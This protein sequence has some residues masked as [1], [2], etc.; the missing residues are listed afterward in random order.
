[1][2][3]LI[4]FSLRIGSGRLRLSHVNAVLRTIARIHAR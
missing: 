4:E 2:H 1:M 3:R